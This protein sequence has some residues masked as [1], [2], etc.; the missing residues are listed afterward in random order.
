MRG[1]HHS[2]SPRFFGAF[3]DSASA[4]SGHLG[5]KT[6]ISRC[7]RCLEA[8]AR[9][10]VLWREEWT[11]R[12]KVAASLP[13]CGAAPDSPRG[14]HPGAALRGVGPRSRSVHPV[15]RGQS[16]VVGDQTGAE[17]LRTRV[18]GEPLGS[19]SSGACETVTAAHGIGLVLPRR[20]DAGRL[21][22]IRRVTTARCSYA[23]TL[24]VRGTGQHV[25]S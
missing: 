11:Q 17:R 1:L 22:K 10:V 16:P 12:R 13:T 2:L 14:H 25:A 4:K 7:L 6:A 8:R 24:Q 21:S 9:T 18:A 15:R 5:G 3:F 20:H 19:P 23:G